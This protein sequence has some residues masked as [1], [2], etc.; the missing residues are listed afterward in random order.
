MYDL[1]KEAR[2]YVQV[3]HDSAEARH[4]TYGEDYM[5]S[6]LWDIMLATE[7]LL[8]KIDEELRE[9]KNDDRNGSG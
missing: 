8:H 2:K 9:L 7:N 1:L 6:D 4:D 3:A 5:S